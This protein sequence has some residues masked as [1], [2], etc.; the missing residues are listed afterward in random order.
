M[1][2]NENVEGV[3]R[4]KFRKLKES[5]FCKYSQIDPEPYS[6]PQASPREYSVEARIIL[7]HDAKNEHLNKESPTEE[8]RSNPTF[9]KPESN[10]IQ[11]T[12]NQH[13]VNESNL[14]GEGPG[15]I[16]TTS[17]S[18]IPH[19][20]ISSRHKNLINQCLAELEQNANR[21]FQSEKSETDLQ[22][23]SEMNRAI[24][25]ETNM[26]L[27]SDKNL[28]LESETILEVG[29]KPDLDLVLGSETNL[30]PRSETKLE[31][32]IDS[33]DLELQY[34]NQIRDLPLLRPDI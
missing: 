1:T 17:A 28:E 21:T 30:D 4:S 18:L 15:D 26:E 32:R 29:S 31:L 6:V 11:E 23:G 25:S 20:F 14:Q 13:P 10:K 7:K 5:S 8:P 27:G 2:E 19:T 16:N 34:I 24:G 33:S 12:W 22:L 3:N 9:N